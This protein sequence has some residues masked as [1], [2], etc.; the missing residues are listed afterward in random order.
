MYAENIHDTA[1]TV[2]EDI[3]RVSAKNSVNRYM[4]TTPPRALTPDLVFSGIIMQKRISHSLIQYCIVK[5][6]QQKVVFE[7]V[8]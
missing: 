8:T 4:E 3:H 7:V 2:T 5:A 1:P 6:V